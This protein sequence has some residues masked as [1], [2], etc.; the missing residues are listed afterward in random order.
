MPK[1]AFSINWKAYEA[2]GV[3]VGWGNAYSWA[4]G[5]RNDVRFYVDNTPTPGSIGQTS[6]GVYGHV[7][8][9]ESV[10]GDG[11]INITEYNNDYG[12]FLYSGISRGG[13]FGARTIA[14]GSV[15]QYSF[16][17]KK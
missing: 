10:N 17:H 13:D 3:G 16:I 12:T 4:N 15:W 8:W 6:V 9:V 7:F 11:S 1:S 14:A 2:W 5:A